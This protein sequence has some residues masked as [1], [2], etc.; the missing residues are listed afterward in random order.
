M[1]LVAFLIVLVLVLTQLGDGCVL[2]EIL[3]GIVRHTEEDG[4]CLILLGY[5]VMEPNHS[6]SVDD[7][8]V[9]TDD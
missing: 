8:W 2:T 5:A 9:V 6:G 3:D 4:I 7:S 1:Q